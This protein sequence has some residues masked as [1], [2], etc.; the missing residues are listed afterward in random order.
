MFFMGSYSQENFK[1]PN[2]ELM[3][4]KNG[5][6]IYLVQQDEVPLIHFRAVVPAG[7]KYDQKGKNGLSNIVANSLS[8]LLY[9]SPSPRDR[10]KSRMPSSA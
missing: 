5:L 7:Y 10:Q 8:C 1:L 6:Q 3:T 2:H 9:T 4:L